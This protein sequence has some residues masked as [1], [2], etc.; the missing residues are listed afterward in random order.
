M[1]FD[2][3]RESLSEELLPSNPAGELSDAELESAFG[4]WGGGGYGYTNVYQHNES[5]ALL[6]ELN[7]FSL[8]VISNIALLGSV[9]QAC[10]KG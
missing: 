4:G 8:S 3:T 6:C 5:Y 9:T 2:I 1:K 10:I 7:V